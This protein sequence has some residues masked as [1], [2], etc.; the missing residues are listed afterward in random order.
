MSMDLKFLARGPLGNARRFTAYNINGFKFRTLT[1][2]EGLRTQNSG[3]FLTS[4]AACV[5]S[6]VD[7]N[8]RQADLPYYGKL[9][10]IIE[11]NY[12]GRFKVVLFKCKW[13]DTKRER[14]YINFDRLIHI[15]DREE[16]KPYMEASQAQMV[17][18]EVYENE[19][20]EDQ[21]LEK[22]YSNDN[23]Y[24]QLATNQLDD[25]IHD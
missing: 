21:Q 11:L 2:D 1:R 12:Y 10:D 15:G 24:V 18:E 8:L 16:L 25:D 6:S 9:E 3:V 13:V 20:Y 4:N 7:R 22:F 23:E 14:G 5:S 19:P 17:E